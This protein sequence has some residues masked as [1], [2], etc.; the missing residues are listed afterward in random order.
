MYYRTLHQISQTLH[1]YPNPLVCGDGQRHML[2]VYE[3]NLS[4][5]G[6]DDRINPN[7][8]KEELRKPNW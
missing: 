2:K 7:I 8:D 3:G 4:L 6:V 5:Y 1:P